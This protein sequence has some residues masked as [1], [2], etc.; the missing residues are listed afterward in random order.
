MILKM[1]CARFVL[2]ETESFGLSKCKRLIV[3][4]ESLVYGGFIVCGCGSEK[5]IKGPEDG[6]IKEKTVC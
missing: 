1:C 5:I 6:F 3:M 4:V 2:N